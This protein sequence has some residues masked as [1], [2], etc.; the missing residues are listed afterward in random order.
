VATQV[1]VSWLLAVHTQFDA[2]GLLPYT[3]VV[4]RS[5]AAFA[6]LSLFTLQAQSLAFHVHAAGGSDQ[7]NHH[8]HGPAIHTHGA[9]DFDKKPHVETQDLEARAPAITVAV[10]AAT[11]TAAIV[12]YMDMAEATASPS[13][14]LSGDTRA[15][16]VRS[17]GP[18]PVDHSSLRGPPDS[19]I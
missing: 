1:I 3:R 6:A 16:E 17:H 2:R 9:A 8:K 13:L 4:R 11:V 12:V 5:I 18:P 19:I 14:Q 7:D 15:I 10:P